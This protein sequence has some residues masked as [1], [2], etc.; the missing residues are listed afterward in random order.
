M[1][2]LSKISIWAQ[3]IYIFWVVGVWVDFEPF[4]II[5]SEELWPIFLTLLAVALICGIIGS[6]KIFR[7]GSA[8]WKR[9]V[10]VI[11]LLLPLVLFGLTVVAFQFR[12][13]IGP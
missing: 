4:G 7:D 5:T 2:L 9:S 8:G 1:H 10:S 12:F 6:V 11:I 13:T 3:V